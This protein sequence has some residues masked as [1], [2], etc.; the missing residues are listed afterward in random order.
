MIHNDPIPQ[1][2]EKSA[3]TLGFGSPDMI[4]NATAPVATTTENSTVGDI[5]QSKP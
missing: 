2:K 4:Q 5:P 1:I 3:G